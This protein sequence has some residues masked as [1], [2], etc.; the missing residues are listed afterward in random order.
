MVSVIDYSFT[1]L[2]GRNVDVS[3]AYED[4]VIVRNFSAPVPAEERISGQEWYSELSRKQKLNKVQR[5]I[6][7][8]LKS[9]L[10][11]N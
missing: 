8:F 11:G 10:E 9:N 4:G 5:V 6:F 2:S 1:D 3:V 7:N